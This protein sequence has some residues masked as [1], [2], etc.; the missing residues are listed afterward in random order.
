MKHRLY[1]TQYIFITYVYEL[2]GENH[3]GSFSILLQALLIY[4][5]IYTH[6]CVHRRSIHLSVYKERVMVGSESNV[7]YTYMITIF[8]NSENYLLKN[9]EKNE[10]R[11]SSFYDQSVILC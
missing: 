1:I 4:I 2:I 11:L 7:K 8:S 6:I 9:L 3:S 10:L 5:Y